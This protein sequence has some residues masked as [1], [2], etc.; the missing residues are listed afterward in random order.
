MGHCSSFRWF[1]LSSICLQTPKA[2]LMLCFRIPAPLPTQPWQEPGTR[3]ERAWQCV[4]WC[5][6]YLLEGWLGL[7]GAVFPVGWALRMQ[8]G[9]ISAFPPPQCC[10]RPLA[11]TQ[12]LLTQAAPA[13]AG[14]WDEDR[15]YRLEALLES[16][17]A[18]M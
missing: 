1:F 12:P 15:L 6:K 5:L 8:C 4:L 3:A 17:L 14:F 10:S 2:Q 13:L 11:Q 18:G 7:Q 16:M 9:L